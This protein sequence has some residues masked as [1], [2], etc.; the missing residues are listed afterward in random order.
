MIININGNPI[1][2][3]G[4]LTP[5][6]GNIGIYELILNVGTDIGYTG[7]TYAAL[8]IPDRFQ[9]YY[10]ANPYLESSLVADS[11]FVGDNI[12]DP[13]NPLGGITL[14]DYTMDNYEFDGDDFVATGSTTDI[15]IIES[16]VADNITEPTR[17]DG[18]LLFNKTTAEPQSIRIVITGSPASGTTA[19]NIQGICPTPEEELIEGEEKLMY[20]FFDSTNKALQTRSAKFILGDSPVKFY[21]N[22]LGSV[23]FST[24]GYTGTSEYINDGITYWRIDGT[25]EILETGTL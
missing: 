3:C 7:I 20:C 9:I 24:Y 11:K 22:K 23:D 5:A 10:G 18:T 4:T 17:G 12:Q 25:G 15:T 6:G 14:G 21:T 19:W 16:D 8:G 13:S 2:P 1:V